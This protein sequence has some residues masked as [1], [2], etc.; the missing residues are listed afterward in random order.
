MFG[1]N[2]L[3]PNHMSVSV[4]RRILVSAAAVSLFAALSASAQDALK[5]WTKGGFET[6]QYRNVFA[7]MGYAPAE[8]D[9][10]LESIFQEVYYG[11]DK[12]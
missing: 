7:E 11:P 9:A 8:I 3:K 6:H 10:K 4:F 2:H 5:P 1:M 12:V